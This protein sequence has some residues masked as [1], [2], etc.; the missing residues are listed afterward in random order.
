MKRKRTGGDTK[1]KGEKDGKEVK[2]VEERGKKCKRT[3]SRGNRMG[4]KGV[5]KGE[6]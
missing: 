4:G 2:S 5:S 1:Y 3:K 6:C